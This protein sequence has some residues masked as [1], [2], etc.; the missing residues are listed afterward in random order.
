M[1]R[2]LEFTVHGPTAYRRHDAVTTPLHAHRPRST[3]NL[4]HVIAPSF[5]GEEEVVQGIAL[6][7]HT[8]VCASPDSVVLSLPAAVFNALVV[9][10]PGTHPYATGAKLARTIEGRAKWCV[11]DSC[12]R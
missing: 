12:R 6:R 11:G 3:L 10:D 8:A 4:H 7:N 2:L 1:G 9:G 5:C